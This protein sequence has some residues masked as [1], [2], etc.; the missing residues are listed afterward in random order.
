M[1]TFPPQEILYI[2]I[3]E[4]IKANGEAF[5]CSEDIDKNELN[6]LSKFFTVS[7]KDGVCLFTEKKMEDFK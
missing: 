7:E 5:I 6:H 1:I 3:R 4:S 2:G